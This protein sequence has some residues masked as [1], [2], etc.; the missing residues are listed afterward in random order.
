[1]SHVEGNCGNTDQMT[2][3]TKTHKGEIK[4]AVDAGHITQ[5]Q[6]KRLKRVVSKLQDEML[7]A[8]AKD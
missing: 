4:A 7:E 3:D 5:R 2:I 1:M 6:A 8:W